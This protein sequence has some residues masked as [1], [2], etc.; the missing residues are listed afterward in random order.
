MF[1]V[2]GVFVFEKMIDIQI[3]NISENGNNEIE[4]IFKDDFSTIYSAI[5]KGGPLHWNEDNRKYT[6]D[7]NKNVAL[8]CLYNSQNIIDFS[9]KV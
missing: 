1:G 6:R 3:A 8:K 7:L 4:N 2:F 5:W 9:N